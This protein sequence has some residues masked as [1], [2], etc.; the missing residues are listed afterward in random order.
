MAGT[1]KWGPPQTGDS[2]LGNHHIQ[3]LCSNFG[4]AKTATPNNKLYYLQSRWRS[5]LPLPYPIRQLLGMAIAIDLF[6]MMYPNQTKNLH[7]KIPIRE[8]PQN[9]HRFLSFDSTKMGGHFMT[10]ELSI[11]KKILHSKKKLPK[12]RNLNSC[13]ALIPISNF[14]FWCHHLWNTFLGRSWL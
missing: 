11:Q 7:S 1:W 13:S 6:A 3:F 9:C 12:N 8:I 2:E 5:P 10:P 14:F 4:E